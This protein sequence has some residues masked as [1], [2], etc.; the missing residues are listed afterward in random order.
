MARINENYT[1]LP[2]SYLFSD[3][4]KRVSAFTTANPDRS[5]IRLGIG[6]VTRPLAPSVISALHQAVTE[7]AESA[8][9]RGYG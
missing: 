5:I 7:Q 3:I 8:T 6:D 1:R 4:A 2:G 9:F